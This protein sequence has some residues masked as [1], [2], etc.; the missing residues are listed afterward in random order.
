MRV[1]TAPEMVTVSVALGSG[2]ESR[3]VPLAHQWRQ[4]PAAPDG[5][6]GARVPGGAIAGG[7][8]RMARRRRAMKAS[9]KGSERSLG[10]AG[11]YLS[12]RLTHLK[13]Q[14]APARVGIRRTS[15]DDGPFA[16]LAGMVGCQR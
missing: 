16:Q 4:R 3:A 6:T 10:V 15:L 5:R 11:G 8:T 7:G 9:G 2:S 13:L 12:K 14:V 1:I